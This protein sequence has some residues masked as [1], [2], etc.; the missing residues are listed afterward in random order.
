MYYTDDMCGPEEMLGRIIVSIDGMEA[1][2]EEIT[3]RCEDGT[4]FVMGHVQDCCE[5][6]GL[7]EAV[8]DPQDLVGY[9]LLMAEEATNE[10]DP[11]QP[12]EYPESWTW[13]FYKFATVRGYVT[14]RWLGES[15][16]YYSESVDISKHAPGS[17][18]H[19]ST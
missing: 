6:V 5:S 8:G 7:E 3:F 11:G 16:G 14:L 4:R 2:S 19:A 9:P 12:D 17:S 10:K 18:F 15:N 13:T 1:G